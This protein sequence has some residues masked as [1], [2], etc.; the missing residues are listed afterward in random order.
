[1]KNNPETQKAY[2]KEYYWR[3]REKQ[4]AVAE[5][6]QS[7]N[8]ERVR[9]HNRRYYELHKE[10]WELKNAERQALIDNLK[11]KPCADCGI[12]YPPYVM[13]FDHLPQYEKSFSIGA[14]AR[15][16]SL[17]AIT[18]EAT[19]CEVVCSNCHRERTHQRKTK[20]EEYVV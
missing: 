16:R 15:S 5:E 9:E 2:R 7:N 18:E 19:K 20:K 17:E 8:P 11:S 13:D 3:N 1:M 4:R 12:Q 14:L 10:K 6:W